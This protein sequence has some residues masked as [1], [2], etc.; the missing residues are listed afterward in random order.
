MEERRKTGGAELGILEVLGSGTSTG[1]P[2]M[3]CDCSVCTSAS[4]LDTRTRV[5]VLIRTRDSNILIDTSPDLRS[6]YLRAGQPRI[7]AILYTHHHFDHI[8]GFDD[9]RGLNFRARKPIPIYGLPETIAEIKRFFAYAFTTA[10]SNSSAPKVIPHTLEPYRPTEIAGLEIL[11][12]LLDHGPETRVLGFATGNAAYCTDCSEIPEK[13]R[14][15]LTGVTNLVLDGLRMKEHP[16]H[17]TIA[18][19]SSVAT[20]LGA[21]T[22]WLTH[23][24]HDT[25]HRTG[26]NQTPDHVRIAFDGLKIP[27]EVTKFY[28]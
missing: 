18:E 6:Q 1:I 24:A 7:D 2:T 26:S 16:M 22:T 15:R 3:G 11:P 19:A 12:L 28:T 8:G 17:M 10:A 14:E 13:T 25:S 20:K 5:S 21:G 9:I 4:I 27:I 23:L